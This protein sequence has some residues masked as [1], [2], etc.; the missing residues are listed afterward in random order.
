LEKSS[1][2]GAVSGELS[3]ACVLSPSACLESSSSGASSGPSVGL[4]ISAA[5]VSVGLA[6]MGRSWWSVGFEGWEVGLLAPGVTLILEGEA[7]M[8][9]WSSSSVSVGMGRSSW[10][11]GSMH[12]P[13]RVRRQS[14]KVPLY[15]FT[16]VSFTTTDHLPVPLSPLY[17][18]LLQVL[19]TG[20][21][22]GEKEAYQCATDIKVQST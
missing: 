11:E 16:S 22:V 1:S 15:S 8:T 18:W 13:Q 6:L 10:D 5:A 20:T 17:D 3:G 19:G 12:S 9:S 7:E 2:A 21:S 14:W 4:V